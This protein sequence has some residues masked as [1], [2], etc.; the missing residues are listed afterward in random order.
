VRPFPN[1]LGHLLILNV[2]PTLRALKHARE[3]RGIYITGLPGIADSNI[4]CTTHLRSHVTII[5]PSARNTLSSQSPRHL[6]RGMVPEAVNIMLDALEVPRTL[7]SHL[8]P[9]Q[10]KIACWP[11]PLHLGIFILLHRSIDHICDQ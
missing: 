1:Q 4:L 2:T 6:Y 11:S 8:L 7:D 5:Y 9:A 3:S 10:L